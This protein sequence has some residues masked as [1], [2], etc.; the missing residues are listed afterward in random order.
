MISA[1]HGCACLPEF[2]PLLPLVVTRP[3][4]DPALQRRVPLATVRGRRHLPLVGLFWR[5][6]AGAARA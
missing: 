2:M 5:L 6:C 1:G 4:V 3:L